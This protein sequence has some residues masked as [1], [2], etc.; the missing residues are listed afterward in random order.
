MKSLGQIIFNHVLDYRTNYD[1]HNLSLT[2]TGASA[3]KESYEEFGLSI[4]WTLNLNGSWLWSTLLKV[5]VVVIIP[6]VWSILKKLLFGSMLYDNWPYLPLSSSSAC[7]HWYRKHNLGKGNNKIHLSLKLF[8]YIIMF[9]VF[10]KS[11]EMANKFTVKSWLPLCII[12]VCS[13]VHH[14]VHHK[15]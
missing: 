2:T 10:T 14:T 8:M 6:D 1:I 5:F 12:N 15:Q 3:V 7:K 4:T 9:A 13:Y 11:M